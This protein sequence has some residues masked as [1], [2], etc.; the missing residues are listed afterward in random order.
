MPNLSFLRHKPS[1]I[2]CVGLNYHTHAKELGMS[3]LRHPVLFLKPPT[4]LIGPGDT[5]RLPLQSKQVDYEAE[6]DLVIRKKVKNIPKSR[7]KEFIM[8][9]VCLNDVTARD[10][11]KADGQWIRA[12]G[13]DTF[14]PVGP[15]VAQLANPNN[16]DIQL[17]LNGKI[18]QKSTTSELIFRVEEIVSFVSFVMTLLPGDIISTGTPQGIGPMKPGDTVAVSIEG[19][20]TLENNVV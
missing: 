13:F 1:K 15:R 11:Q 16:V 4:A 8:G 19:I 7:A 18:R 14:C 2:I 3:A 12:K 5:I 9:Y 10:L 17:T 20:G 6:L